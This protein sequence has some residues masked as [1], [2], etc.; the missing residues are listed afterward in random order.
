[1]QN[2]LDR[3]LAVEVEFP[4]E[5]IE[6]LDAWIAE[7]GKELTRPDAIK[8]IVKNALAVDREWQS[9]KGAAGWTDSEAGDS[10]SDQEEQQPAP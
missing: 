9:A 3:G 1:M 5:D 2:E 4:P 8:S 7:H 6:E 10:K